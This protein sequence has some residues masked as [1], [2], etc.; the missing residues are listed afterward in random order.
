MSKIVKSKL[1]KSYTVVPNEILKRSDISARAKGLFTYL[2]SLPE[3][4]VIYKTEVY[5]HFTEGRRA[6]ESAFKE[7]EEKGYLLGA[8]QIKADGKFQGK[9]YILY[10]F[11]FGSTDVQNEQR[12]M[13]EM[14]NGTDVQNVPLL[15][16]NKQSTNTPTSGKSEIIHKVIE[17]L[18][19]TCSKNFSPKSKLNRDKITARL[20]E[21]FLLEDFK[22]VIEIKN[23]KWSGDPK[24]KDFLRPETLFG[25][26]FE[27]YLNEKEPAKKVN[28]T[29][30][31]Y[32]ELYVWRV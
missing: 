7:L 16:T 9:D 1:N 23:R 26:K 17:Y 15:S 2:H 22:K 13:D 29:E 11:P 20:N 32:K 18:N 12:P 3:N 14:Y 27:A 24:M 4:W 30:Q 10:Q 21:G 28:N 25:N 31:Q 19:K 6:M 5:N 8:D